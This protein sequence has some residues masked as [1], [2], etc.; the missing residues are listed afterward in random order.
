MNPILSSQAAK[1]KVH[2]GIEVNESEPNITRRFVT[3]P[4]RSMMKT[5]PTGKKRLFSSRTHG[6]RISTD[7]NRI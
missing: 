4:S 3:H 6:L 2:E 5:S 1:S 7:V